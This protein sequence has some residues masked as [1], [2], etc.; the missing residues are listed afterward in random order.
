MR[1]PP[2][3]H[4]GETPLYEAALRALARRAYSVFE[5]RTYLERRADESLLAQLVLAR[6]RE[7]RLLD[8]ARYAREFA[9]ARAA[10]RRQGPH[11]ITRELRA[12][13]VSDEHIESAVQET[14]ANTDE[15]ALVRKLIERR[16]RVARGPWDEKKRASLYRMLLRSGFDAELIRREL[17]TATRGEVPGT[18]REEV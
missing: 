6:L 1:A 2:R 7:E 10:L 16:T 12:R 3:K 5:M 14:F 18:D 11:R 15:A 8:D 9:R 17:R 4:S 13:G